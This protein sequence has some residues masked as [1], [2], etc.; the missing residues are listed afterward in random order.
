MQYIQDVVLIDPLPPHTAQMSVTDIEILIR[1][2]VKLAVSKLAQHFP[3]SNL[4]ADAAIK[5]SRGKKKN[6]MS[7]SMANIFFRDIRVSRAI[8]GFNLDGTERVEERKIVQL[9]KEAQEY[10]EQ[11]MK[12]ISLKISWADECALGEEVELYESGKTY[13]QRL[14]PLVGLEMFKCK[15]NYIEPVNT[16]YHHNILVT[17]FSKTSKDAPTVQQVIEHIRPWCRSVGRRYPRVSYND[18][19]FTIE[20]DPSGIDGSFIVSFL[21]SWP[22]GTGELYF[23]FKKK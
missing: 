11:C 8:L 14:A 16:A 17:T 12:T 13:T 22:Y 19:H 20:L 6:G 9:S 2:A 1:T 5:I 15:Q 23:N 3:D 21:F 10:R 18:K 7:Y 4:N